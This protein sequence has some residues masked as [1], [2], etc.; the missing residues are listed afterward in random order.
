M[1]SKLEALVCYWA[2]YSH[3]FKSYAGGIV[4]GL[5]R[6]FSC[7]GFSINFW[8]GM[9]FHWYAWCILFS[10]WSILG[11]N[12]G[13]IV[14]RIMS[15]HCNDFHYKCRMSALLSSTSM[16][17]EQKWYYRLSLLVCDLSLNSFYYMWLLIR[18]LL[19]KSIT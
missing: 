7:L 12:P 3:I 8:K 17:M 5:C 15:I 13:S 14:S 10:H 2:Q 9:W 1:Q 16:E 6:V 18:L 4:C 19:R 11:L